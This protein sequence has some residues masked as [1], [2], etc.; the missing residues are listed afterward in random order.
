M[1]YSINAAASEEDHD[2]DLPESPYQP[3]NYVFPSRS[4]GLSKPL[5]RSFQSSWFSR[6]HWL[7]YDASKDCAFCFI[8]C[9]AIKSNKVRI[10]GVTEHAFIT[11]GFTNWKDATR[12]YNRHEASDFH[13]KCVEALQS[14]V[15]IGEVLSS[16]HAQEKKTNRDYLLKGAGNPYCLGF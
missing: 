5:K 14:Q 9:K 16:Q 8:C 7:H 4:F 1:A 10:T 13:R 15:D 11:K 12:I 6:F 2:V 3:T